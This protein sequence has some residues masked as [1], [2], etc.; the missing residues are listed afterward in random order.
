MGWKEGSGRWLLEEY[1]RLWREGMS[2]STCAAG[3][4]KAEQ[5]MATPLVMEKTGKKQG[6][7]VP[8]VRW[9]K[10]CWETM[11]G[12]FLVYRLQWIRACTVQQYAYG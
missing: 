5:G 12:V 4:G 8:S 9:A 10:P 3:L 2:K 6:V 7:I 11:L 1:G